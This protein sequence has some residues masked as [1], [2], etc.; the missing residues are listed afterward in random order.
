MDIKYGKNGYFLISR[1]QENVREN[2]YRSL[3]YIIYVASVCRV[4]TL[5][6]ITSV[7]WPFKTISH[8][9]VTAFIQ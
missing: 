2:A 7:L 6:F 9:E 4:Y 5:A 8:R 1:L 3:T